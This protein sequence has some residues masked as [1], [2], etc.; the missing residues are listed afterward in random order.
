MKFLLGLV[1]TLGELAR[2][3]GL[4]GVFG[5][6]LFDG[7]LLWLLP[8]INDIVVIS[9]VVAKHSLG[10]AVLAVLVATG[11]SILGAMASYR[12]GHRGGAEILRKR[13]PPK[14]L[15]RVEAWTNRMGAIP[16]GV[17]AIMPPPFPY[18][19]FVI[20]AGVMNVPKARFRISVGL[21][22]GIRYSLEAVL[23]L[24]LGHHLLHRLDSF[25]WAALEPALILLAVA[26]TVWGIYRLQFSH[27]DSN[28]GR[29]LQ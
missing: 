26:L 20:S 16:V 10:W 12:I 29:W 2:T 17:A 13:F 22:R 4:V 6:T 9:F 27:R 7:S 24:Y 21:G 11:G 8:G 15:T 3:W 25:Y 14:L 28:P 5:L 23:A 19:P 18:A 1:H